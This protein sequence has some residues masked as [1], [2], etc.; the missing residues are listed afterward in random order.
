LTG[1]HDDGNNV[2]NRIV[3]PLKKRRRTEYRLPPHSKIFRLTCGAS[4]SESVSLS[5][6]APHSCFVN[7]KTQKEKSA[8]GNRLVTG[9]CEGNAFLVKKG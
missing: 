4:G 8:D 3:T 5:G 9:V 7:E 1:R 2:S 6:S